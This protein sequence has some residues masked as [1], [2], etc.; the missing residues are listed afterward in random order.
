VFGDG[1]GD[2]LT[3]VSGEAGAEQVVGVGG[4]AVGAGGAD[5]GAAVPAGGQ[6]GAGALN[7]DG[8]V[9]VEDLRAARQMD[10]GGAPADGLDLSASLPVIRGAEPGT[11]QVDHRRLQR[12]GGGGGGGHRRPPGWRVGEEGVRAAQRASKARVAVVTSTERA[13]P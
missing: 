7:E 6:R 2:V 4:V 12:L 10:G 8:T 13:G 11:E 9:A 1:V 3:V 5:R